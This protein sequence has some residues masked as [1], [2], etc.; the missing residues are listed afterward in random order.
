MAKKKENA[1]VSVADQMAKDIKV[2]EAME[3]NTSSGQFIKLQS[4]V[5]SINDTPVPGNKIVV[6]IVGALMENVFYAGKYDASNPAPPDC[7]AFGKVE[8]DMKP[9]EKVFEA[10]TDVNKTCTGCP[11]NEW[12]SADTGKGKACKN[13]R[14]LAL[15][16]AGTVSKGGD[17]KLFKD[18]SDFKESDIVFLRVPVTSV[19]G[20]S[21][22]VKQ[23]AKVLGKPPY[24][25]FTEISVEPDKDTTFKVFFHTLDEVPDK[26]LPIMIDRHKEAEVA[27]DFPYSSYD[28]DGKK[29][30]GKKKTPAKKK[31]KRK[32]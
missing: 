12:G 30:K 29:P 23:S 28:D 10:G 4:G 14:R 16:P 22:M 20:Y 18:V 31:T 26:L 3:A 7:Y 19:K 11:N 15:I 32:F 5:M 1:I 25:L 6:A 24:A 8:E 21:A 2:A 13:T 17:V 9:H 27:L